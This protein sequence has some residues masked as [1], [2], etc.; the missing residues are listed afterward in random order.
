MFSRRWYYVLFVSII[1]MALVIPAHAQDEEPEHIRG[2]IISVEGS[3]IVLKTGA[4]KRVSFELPKN[5]TVISLTK[6]SYTMV[7]FGVY[8][9]AVAVK[10]DQYSPIVR[11]SL[12][13]LHKGFELRLIDEEL[14]GIALGHK[15]W[16]LTDTSIIAHGWIDDIEDRVI[17]IKYG[18]T[19]I[20]ETDVEIPRDVPVHI[21]KLGDKNLIKTGKQVFIGANKGKNGD[22][23]ASFIFVGEDDSVPAM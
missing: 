3:S 16:D 10:L 8:V 4:N 19:E 1:V 20:E 9:G 7:D 23:V 5:L 14:R 22:Y 17:S 18:P 15:K 2:Q 21:M 13:W 11:D 6:G 12:S